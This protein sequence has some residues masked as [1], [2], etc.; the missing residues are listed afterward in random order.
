MAKKRHHSSHKATSMKDGGMHMK[1][2]SKD[3]GRGSNKVA[4]SGFASK[5][6]MPSELN[7]FPNQSFV[8]HWGSKPSW[9]G[10]TYPDGI[11]DIDG[12]EMK[13]MGMIKKQASDRLY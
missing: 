13:M 10:D 7:G 8:A 3:G 12:I 1:H 6:G 4:M 9:P 5:A 11:D 2:D